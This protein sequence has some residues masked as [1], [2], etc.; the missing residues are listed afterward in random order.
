MILTSKIVALAFQQLTTPDSPG[1]RAKDEK[2][3][4]S[5]SMAHNYTGI[6]G[7]IVGADGVCTAGAIDGG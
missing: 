2:R 3:K 4:A 7:F 5:G 6:T 1:K